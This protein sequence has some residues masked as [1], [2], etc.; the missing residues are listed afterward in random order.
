MAPGRD[1]GSFRQRA[2]IDLLADQ[3]LDDSWQISNGALRWLA[4]T[5]RCLNALPSYSGVLR[6]RLP[7]KPDRLALL[8]DCVKRLTCRREAGSGGDSRAARNGDGAARKRSE[9]IPAHCYR[10]GLREVSRAG[11]SG[12]DDASPLQ[13]RRDP[14]RARAVCCASAG[15]LNL[16]SR[17]PLPVPRPPPPP[18]NEKALGILLFVA[19]AARRSKCSRDPITSEQHPGRASERAPISNKAEPS[20]KKGPEKERGER[21]CPKRSIAPSG[22]FF[23][24]AVRSARSMTAPR[25]K[26]RRPSSSPG[27]RDRCASARAPAPSRAQSSERSTRTPS[28]R[29]SVKPL[30][31]RMPVVGSLDLLAL[32]SPSPDVV[33]H[34]VRARTNKRGEPGVDDAPGPRLSRARFERRAP[35]RKQS[36][37]NSSDAR[38]AASVLTVRLSHSAGTRRSNEANGQEGRVPERERAKSGGK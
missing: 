37:G 25:T 32:V 24:S 6:N 16:E 1:A 7:R 11:L 8:E 35:H 5:T 20:G 22:R 2:R 28:I 9:R 23:F 14:G 38:R 15:R 19:R 33:R 26:K 31:L 27:A 18:S 10:A 12:R 30:D 34:Y 36:G 17:A 21:T 29:P 13:P 3:H 4:I